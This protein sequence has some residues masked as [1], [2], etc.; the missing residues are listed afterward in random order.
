MSDGTKLKYLKSTAFPS[1]R[2][3]VEDPS[4]PPAVEMPYPNHE[5]WAARA[6]KPSSAANAHGYKHQ[7]SQKLGKMRLSGHSGAHRI[8]KR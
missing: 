8:G 5:G 1:P 4:R 7:E 6:V 3:A 2:T